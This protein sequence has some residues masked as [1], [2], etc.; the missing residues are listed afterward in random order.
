MFIKWPVGL[1]LSLFAVQRLGPKLVDPSI[2]SE[3]TQKAP[4]PGALKVRPLKLYELTLGA[5][6][7]NHH[8]GF[9]K[10]KEI[11]CQV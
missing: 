9:A 3:P 10:S 5:V 7:E 4:P 8:T 6:I 1:L 2:I 11:V